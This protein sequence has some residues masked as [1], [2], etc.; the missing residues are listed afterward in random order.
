MLVHVDGTGHHQF[1]TDFYILVEPAGRQSHSNPG[2]APISSNLEI[3]RFRSLS[4]VQQYTSAP[5][6]DWAI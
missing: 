5:K 4:P 2:D 3:G 6:D 1:A